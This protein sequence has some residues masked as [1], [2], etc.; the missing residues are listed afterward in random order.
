MRRLFP[1]VLACAFVAGLALAPPARAKVTF[2]F[3]YSLD[4]NNF[5]NPSTAN[6]QAARAALVTAGHVY[7]D[8]VLD[9]LTAIT[10]GGINTWTA[11]FTNPGTG[12]T[13]DPKDPNHWDGLP[14][15]NIPTNVLKVYVG[16]R[17]LGGAIGLGGPGGYSGQGDVP[18]ENALQYRGQAGASASPAT[19]TGPWGGSISFDNSVSWNFDLSGPAKN[20]NDFLTVATHELAHILGFGT[21]NSWK[22]RLTLTGGK[23]VGPFTGA[24]AV[25]LYG[26][27]VP[28]ET[29][30]GTNTVA[31]HFAAG[32]MSTVGG[33]TP[34]ETL[35][36][37]DITTGTRKKITLLDWAAIDDVGWDLARP[38]DANADGS[39]DFND[40]VT[41]AQN[42]NITDGQRRWS[43]GDFNYDG[44]INFA[45][46]VL[47]AQNY[48]QTG[49]QPTDPIPGATADFTSDWTTA[50]A[51]AAEVPEPSTLLCATFTF[52]AT[53][54][55]RR[56]RFSE[57]NRP[58]SKS[59]C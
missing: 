13:T 11:L 5:F 3:D 44:N 17:S 51:L 34:Q 56:A 48:G 7:E 46:L 29:V 15:V 58:I 36:D 47:L 41:I 42:Y 35:M 45:D 22:T 1:A 20:K 38:G 59:A 39:I 33:V 43:E 25:T 2:D 30:T 52:L 24:K 9:N 6:G 53:M 31:A 37:P 50:Q 14:N 21:A 16:G 27:P 23:Y 18:F 55:F 54:A 8:R 57:R 32:T 4:V 12:A 28:L 40:L 26:G 49:P 10:P 19:D